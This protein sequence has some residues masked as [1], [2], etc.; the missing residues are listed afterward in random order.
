MAED[1]YLM[2]RTMKYHHGK[3]QVLDAMRISLELFTKKKY[4]L[5]TEGEMQNMDRCLREIG[6]L[7]TNLHL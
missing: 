2:P 1:L 5:P 6:F 7:L 3:W 4:L